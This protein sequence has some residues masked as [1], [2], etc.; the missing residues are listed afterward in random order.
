MA[1]KYQLQRRIIDKRTG[2]VLEDSGAQLQRATA[3]E[4]MPKQRIAMNRTSTNRQTG[5]SETWH[6][7]GLGGENRPVAKTLPKVTVTAK[8]K[9]R[10]NGTANE[11]LEE[12]AQNAYPL[13]QNMRPVERRQMPTERLANRMWRIDPHTGERILVEDT[14]IQ[15]VDNSIGPALSKYGDDYQDIWQRGNRRRV[16]R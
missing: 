12:V 16:E 15:P 13:D 9:P 5:E 14:T 10:Y 2:K 6:D 1:E 8:R 3:E 7:V 11:Y 4:A